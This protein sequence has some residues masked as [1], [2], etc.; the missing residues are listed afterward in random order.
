V[1]RPAVRP[2]RAIWKD[3]SAGRYLRRRAGQVLVALGQDVDLVPIWIETLDSDQCG[4]QQLA[5]RELARLGDARAVAP[6][7]AATRRGCMAGRSAARQAL[8]TLDP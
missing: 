3:E 5:A 8:S 6:L 7:Q 4:A 1:G 2:L